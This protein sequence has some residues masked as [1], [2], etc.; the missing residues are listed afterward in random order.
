MDKNTLGGRVKRFA[1]VGYAAGKA[2]GKYAGVRVLGLPFSKGAH[3]DEL[4]QALGGLKGPVMK[5]AQILATVP[6][7]L[8]REY[9]QEL[10]QLQA[11]APAMGWPFVKRRM[12]TE[13]GSD[14]PDRFGAFEKKASFAASL[15]QVHR[16]EDIDGNPLACKLQYPDMTSA[17]EADLR[18]LKLVFSIYRRYDQAIDPSQIQQELTERLREE[19]DYDR[20]ARHMALYGHMLKDEPHIHVP[21]P[22]PDLST[23]RLLC[24]SWLDGRP[25][26]DFVQ[27]NP[28]IGAILFECT[29]LPQFAW[30]VQNAVNLP[31]YDIYTLIC[32]MYKSVVRFPFGGIY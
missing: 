2:A 30:S 32:W 19:L 23:Q 14:W 12:K 10:A 21:I 16:A 31:V 25:L 18:Q 6:D 15:G 8:P 26:L 7:V 5:L 17:V 27:D 29:A 20:E 3:A 4:R 24:M 9:A 13:L 1:R 11:D 22:D 28:D